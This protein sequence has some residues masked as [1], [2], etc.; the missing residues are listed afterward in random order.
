M[1][2][3]NTR[4]T[5]SSQTSLSPLCQVVTQKLAEAGCLGRGHTGGMQMAQDW[6]P[7][8]STAK[9]WPLDCN[10][11]CFHRALRLPHETCEA[12]KL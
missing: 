1:W 8:P 3:T 12:Y 2:V 5:S 4:L 6:H 7:L 10:T 11:A 9:A